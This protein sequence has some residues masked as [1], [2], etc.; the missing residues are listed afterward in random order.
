MRRSC[1]VDATDY[2]LKVRNKNN[3]LVHTDLNA[4]GVSTGAASITYSPAG[5][6]SVDRTL[7]ARLQDFPSVKD[8]GVTGDGVTDD[9]TGLQAALDA[10]LG[11]VYMPPGVY[12]VTDE[13]VVP[14]WVRFHWPQSIL[15]APHWVCV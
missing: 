8:F 9:T 15:E 6:G 12:I 1:Y 14:D 5:T 2:S 11:P 4:T 3:T 10:G 7:A 13:L